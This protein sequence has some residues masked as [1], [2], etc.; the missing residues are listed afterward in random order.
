MYKPHV[1]LYL[2]LVVFFFFVSHNVHAV[3]MYLNESSTNHT[4]KANK[5]YPSPQVFIDVG[6]G[7]VDGGA[8]YRHF[9]EKHINLQVSKKLYDQ[10]SSNGYDVILN[11]DGDYALSEDNQ[12]LR[13]PSRHRKD[14]AQR[15]ELANHIN[16]QMVLSIHVNISQSKASGPIVLYQKKGKTLQSYRLAVLIQHQLNDVYDKQRRT[17]V[18]KPYYILNYVQAPAVIIE[19][20]FISSEH[21]RRW[22]TTDKGQSQLS[23][24]IV[25]AVEQ[26]FIL[27][28]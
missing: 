17:V 21:D 20:G 9:Q 6:H 16:P 27:Y 23:D 5:A 28:E 3:P 15:K 8:V 19:L 26:Y 11:R 25:M 7:G 1:V 2:T 22:L 14:L 10:L 18:G 13:I 4:H 24:A 12:W